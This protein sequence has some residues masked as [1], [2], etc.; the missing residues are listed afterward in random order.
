MWLVA[1]VSNSANIEYLHL[2]RKFLPAP[3]PPALSPTALIFSVQMSIASFKTTNGIVYH[4]LF[5]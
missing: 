4:V 2:P 3:A 1:N 5:L